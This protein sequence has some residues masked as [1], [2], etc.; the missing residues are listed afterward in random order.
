M[1]SENFHVLGVVMRNVNVVAKIT[2]EAIPEIYPIFAFLKPAI[3]PMAT[4]I[5][6]APIMFE[7][8]CTDKNE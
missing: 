6:V 1:P 7:T 3:N 2:A 8:T 5:S 4:M